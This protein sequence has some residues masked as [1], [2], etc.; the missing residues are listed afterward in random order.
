MLLMK[1]I[2]Q[3]GDPVLRKR[4]QDVSLPLSETD[5]NTLRLMME[6]IQNSQNETLVETYDLRPSVGL[7]APQI[8]LSQKLFCIHTVDE[9]GKNLFSRAFV[10]PKILSYSEEKTYLPGGEGCLS[11][12]ESKN[13]LV[14]RSLRIKA[15]AIEVDLETGATESV[16]LK[17]QGYLGIVFQ[18]EY[19]HLR[20]VL[21]VDKV[22]EH[23]PGV[24]PVQF[25]ENNNQ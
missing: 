6:Y 5:M 20:G 1:D 9:T 12:D 17:L 23:L 13:G 21:F 18:H 2:I 25:T 11:V 10:N 16:Y 7:S 3:E 8:N 14:P 4:A 15:R 19:D 24:V 22:V